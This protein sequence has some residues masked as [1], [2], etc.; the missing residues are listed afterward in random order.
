M[1]KVPLIPALHNALMEEVLDKGNSSH[2]SQFQVGG[3]IRQVIKHESQK[4]RALFEFLVQPSQISV[5]IEYLRRKGK[6]TAWVV[7]M[8]NR[9]NISTK[10]DDQGLNLQ[11]SIQNNT[12]G[13]DWLMLGTRNVTDKVR[14]AKFIT[15]RSH[16]VV[17]MELN[18]VYYLRVQDGGISGLGLNIIEEFYRMP[19]DADIGVLVSGFSLSEG[20]QTLH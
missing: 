14:I 20:G 19:R 6:D 11:Y 8:F 17:E 2:G 13:L 16:T 18:D 9:P 7:F 1:A 3:A 5:V 10:T 15:S 12:V 4:R